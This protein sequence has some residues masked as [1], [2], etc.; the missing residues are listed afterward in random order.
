MLEPLLPLPSR[1][2]RRRKYPLRA[3]LNAIFYVLHTG[4]QWRAVPHDLPPWVTA[5]H[6]WWV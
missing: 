6:Y 4:C 5:Y 2:G 1:R 3:L